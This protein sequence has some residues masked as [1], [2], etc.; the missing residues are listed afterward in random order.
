MSITINRVINWLIKSGF[1]LFRMN[2]I[3]DIWL[4]EILTMLVKITRVRVVVLTWG[5]GKCMLQ[6]QSMEHFKWGL[7]YMFVDLFQNM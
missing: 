1:I 5:S 3:V 7:E 4:L 2:E 6:F